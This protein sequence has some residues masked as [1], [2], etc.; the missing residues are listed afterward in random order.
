MPFA[1]TEAMNAHLAEIARTVAPG[2]QQQLRVEAFYS[3]GRVEDVT[4]TASYE[5][6][7]PEMAE[8]DDTGLVTLGGGTGTVAVM[9]RFHELV[10]VARIHEY[11]VCQSARLIT[12]GL[13]SLVEQRADLGVFAQH[14]LVEVTG[15]RFAPGLQQG[16]GGFDD[17]TLLAGEH[18][19][20][21]LWVW[22]FC[23]FYSRFRA[24][25]LLY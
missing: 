20:S 17:G 3:D 15:Q 13:V 23:I 8:C 6:N 5:A 21:D 7:L 2:A 10:D 1:D 25:P 4:R 11:A 24:N 18:K 14:D 19:N 22:S 16:Y 9:V 12:A